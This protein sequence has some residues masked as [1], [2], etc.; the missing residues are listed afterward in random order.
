[1]KTPDDFLGGCISVLREKNPLVHHITN[2]VTANDCANI[3][4]AA[5]GS[6]VMADDE[7]ECA[8]ITAISSALAINIGT[9]NERTIP[10][11]SK[12]GRC[13]NELCIPAILDPVGVGASPMRNRTAER[14]LDEIKFAVV[15][16]NASEIF[17]LAYGKSATKGVDVGEGERASS[18]KALED[19][20]CTV[21]TRFGCVVAVTGPVDVVWGE[22]GVCHI[23]NGRS[24]MGRITGSG[25]MC[26]S[27]VA[28]FLGAGLEPFAA[29]VS[30]VV[31][32]GVAGEL[33]FEACGARGT[34]SLRAG[35]VDVVSGMTDDEL[36]GRATI[37]WTKK[38]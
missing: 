6:P 32:M 2:Y 8:D 21:A 19:A 9:L 25:C 29:A 28:S 30:G 24:E 38:A 16:G 36:A 26:T 31:L 18:L 23:A 12:S 10:S 37:S 20:A 13:A 5:G 11:M 1:M 35:I 3:V 7:G 14:L 33:A 27:L 15:R 22:A 17:H 4:L 34:G